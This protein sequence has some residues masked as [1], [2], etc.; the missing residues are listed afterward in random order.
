MK[1]RYKGEYYITTEP[2]LK[3]GRYT[4]QAWK[5][6]TGKEV[7]DEA[8]LRGIGWAL[9]RKKRKEGDIDA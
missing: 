4:C 5:Y 7:T 9:Q 1:I 3:D 6:R 8:I 2:V